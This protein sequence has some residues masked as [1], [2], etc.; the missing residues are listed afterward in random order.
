[1][2]FQELCDTLDTSK[3]YGKLNDKFVAQIKLL[4]PHVVNPETWPSYGTRKLKN[5][6]GKV[7]ITKGG[8][9]SSSC[10]IVKNNNN[11]YSCTFGPSR[12]FSSGDTRYEV[13][14][15]THRLGGPAVIASNGDEEWFVDGKTH[16]EDGPALNTKF[17][18]AWY[19]HDQLHRLGE[20]AVIVT[21]SKY[22]GNIWAIDGVYHRLDGPAVEYP[23][24]PTYNQFW[25]K[26]KQ[27][28]ESDYWNIINK[29]KPEDREQAIDIMNI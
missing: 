19:K 18:K 5:G 13:D 28:E 21:N 11:Q 4:Q 25:I 16:R 12:V 6:E 24:N 22:G 20:P 9:Q 1:M 15:K 10:I 14:G 3:A 8:A 17:R 26:G 7:T 29:F 27:F 2:T 23:N